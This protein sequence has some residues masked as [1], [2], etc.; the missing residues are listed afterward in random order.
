[1][2]NPISSGEV[3]NLRAKES[4]SNSCG[5]YDESFFPAESSEQLMVALNADITLVN[6]SA[7]LSLLSSYH[8][9]ARSYD[10]SARLE[11]G[12]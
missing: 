10:K 3:K 4:F 11:F 9:V 7:A 8:V 6:S 2:L 5:T 12:K 1:M